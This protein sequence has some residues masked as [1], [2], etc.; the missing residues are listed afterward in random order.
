MKQRLVDQL[1]EVVGHAGSMNQSVQRL[2]GRA[3]IS[4]LPIISVVG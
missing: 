4:E 1:F 3:R 2:D